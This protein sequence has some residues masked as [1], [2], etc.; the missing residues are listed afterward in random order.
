MLVA[1]S[2]L[3]V[4]CSKPRRAGAADRVGHGGM[5]DVEDGTVENSAVESASSAAAVAAA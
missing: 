2:A 3:R 4:A 1:P 5:H